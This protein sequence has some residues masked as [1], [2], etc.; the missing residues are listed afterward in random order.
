VRELEQCL[1]SLLLRGAYL[2]A[3]PE[4]VSFAERVRDGTFTADQLLDGYCAQVS[5]AAGGNWREA[6]RRLGMDWRTVR[7]RAVRAT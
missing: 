7:T 5:A 2:P 1:R 4:Q 6:G 3:R